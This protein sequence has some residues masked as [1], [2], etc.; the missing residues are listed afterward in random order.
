VELDGKT[1]FQHWKPL[2]TDLLIDT[3]KA[4]DGILVHLA[5][6]E[7]QHL[8]DWKKVCRE[9]NVI[10]PEFLVMKNGKLK[11]VTVYAKSCRGAMT[12]FIITNRLSTP[13]DLHHF[14]YEG[15]EFSADY[16]DESHPHFIIG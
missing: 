6:E 4:D 3:V 11:T 7:M 1:M 5:T 16:G 15:F 8:F 9:V 13:E 14:E 12:R 2:L 10:Q